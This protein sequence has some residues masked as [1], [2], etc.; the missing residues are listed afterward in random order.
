VAHPFFDVPVP[1]VIGHRGCA[2]EVPENTLASF[3]RGLAEGAAILE[4]DVH[5]TRDAV[6]VLLHDDRVDRN[7]N[8]SGRVAEFTLGELQRLDAGYRFTPDGGRSHPFRGQ[9]FVIPTLEEA[10]AAFPGARFNLELKEDLPGLV[11]RTLKVVAEAGREDLT[12][13]TAADEA[14]MLDLRSQIESSGSGVAQGACTRDVADFIHSA[15]DASAPKPGPMAL[16]VPAAFGDQPLVTLKF[17][18]HAHA[19]GLAVHVWTINETDEMRALLDLGVDGLVTDHPGRMAN[20]LKARA[21]GA[22]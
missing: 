22:G 17:V 4:S 9:G 15:Q 16:Q 6:P 20:L 14:L 21:S 7:T 1:T 18:E 3:E 8:G 2:G 13:L 12:L 11:A 10:L 5:L 19:H